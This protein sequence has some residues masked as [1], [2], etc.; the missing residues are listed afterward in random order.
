MGTNKQGNALSELVANYAGGCLFL[1]Q[2]LHSADQGWATQVMLSH[3]IVAILQA[4]FVEAP[5]T[6]LVCGY[7]A[8]KGGK[9]GA[10][11]HVDWSKGSHCTVH[12]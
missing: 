9:A 1:C 7:F 12:K 3:R 8:D 11:F 6:N 10:V 2:P 4:T 5:C